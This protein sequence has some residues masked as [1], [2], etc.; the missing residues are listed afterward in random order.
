[1]FPLGNIASKAKINVKDFENTN[2]KVNV[3]QLFMQK[4]TL[5][6]RKKVSTSKFLMQSAA[7]SVLSVLQP[8]TFATNCE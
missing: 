8:D 4:L 2:Q 5:V 3:C 6:K 7:F 1:M